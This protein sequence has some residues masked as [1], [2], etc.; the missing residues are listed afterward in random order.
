[1]KRLTILL[2][3][4]FTTAATAENQTWLIKRSDG[5]YFGVLIQES[6]TVIPMGKIS[7][8]DPTPPTPD[9]P[10]KTDGLH[11][12]VVDDENLRGNLPQAQVNIFTSK[13]FR[14]WLAENTAKADGQP[15]FRFSSNDSL[16]PGEEAR[17]LELPVFVDGWDILMADV[18][19]GKVKFPAWIISNGK[20]GVLEPLPLSVEAAIKRLE[21]FAP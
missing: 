9:T 14:D 1:M 18:K 21:E 19:A 16:A 4:L 12:M 3:L 8:F 11:V 20:K 7:V 2:T 15:S 13:P 17:E 6:G 10:W 5:T